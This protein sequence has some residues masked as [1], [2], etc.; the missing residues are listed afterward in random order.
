MK[1]AAIYS[2]AAALGKVLGFLML[3]IYAH[4]FGSDGYGVL[5]MLEVSTTLLLSL[6]VGTFCAGIMRIY[7][8]EPPERQD[9]VVPTGTVMMLLLA[10]V[11]LAVT[12][13]LATPISQLLFGT[14]KHAILVRLAFAALFFDMTSSTAGMI[15]VIRRHSATNSIIG[16]L[17]ILLFLSLNVYLIVVREM[18]LLG[19][20]IST[21][22]ASCLA[23]L[24][25]FGI[26]TAQC[27]LHFDKEIAR[28]LLRFHWPTM[29]GNLVNWIGGQ[30]EKVVVRFGIGIGGVG[31][32]TM[33]YRLPLLIPTIVVVPFMASWNTKRMELAEAGHP[34]TPRR[35]GSM[36]TT[37]LFL[38]LFAGLLIA[39][40]VDTLLRLLT[41][42]EFWPAARISR[43]LVL[44]SVLASSYL[45]LNF[46]LF[47][48][49]D[50]K[51]FS[52]IRGVTAALSVVLSIVFV[53]L[54]GIAGAAYAACCVSAVKLA[55]GGSIAQKR[56]HIPIEKQRVATLVGVALLLYALIAHGP[57]QTLPGLDPVIQR[58][59]EQLVRLAQDSPLASWRSGRVVE[60]LQAGTDDILLL[61]AKSAYCLLF[62]LLAPVAHRGLWGRVRGRFRTRPAIGR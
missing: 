46:G 4:A 7:H 42:I 59:V 21:L 9:K 26:S 45:Y 41:P 47:F 48:A 15:L 20:Y 40:N 17:R 31:I 29:P 8:E 61:I 56:Y 35:L 55:W 23:G 1:H 53:G 30:I 27:R 54:W 62:G 3:P 32:L 10:L 13:P 19:F 22:V 36:Y 34:D 43:V 51:T 60:G 2:A 12:W 28:K 6:F 5:G 25:L 49:K 37:F 11:I 57:L 14:P 33:G 50:M 52:T 24:V 38:I 18:G 44:K 16:L 39:A 58:G